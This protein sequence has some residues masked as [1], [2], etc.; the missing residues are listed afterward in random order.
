MPQSRGRLGFMVFALAGLGACA[1]EPVANVKANDPSCIFLC[2]LIRELIGP[3][4]PA[5]PVSPPVAVFKH[6]RER[7]RLARHWLPIMKPDLRTTL[8]PAS[9][10]I[11]SEKVDTWRRG[12]VPAAASLDYVSVPGSWAISTVTN[13]FVQLNR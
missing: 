10:A 5:E 8:P 7:K 12:S 1:Q 11:P 4:Q 3:P 13:H 6:P 2:A 9:A